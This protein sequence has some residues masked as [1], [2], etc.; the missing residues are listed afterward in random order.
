MMKKLIGTICALTLVAGM[1]LTAFAMPSAEGGQIK[2]YAA[3]GTELKIIKI[4]ESAVTGSDECNHGADCSGTI[5]II[6]PVT[7][8][9]KDEVKSLD[10]KKLIVGTKYA[11]KEWTKVFELEVIAKDCVKELLP[12]TLT[13]ATSDWVEGDP[14]VAH[15]TDGKWELVEIDEANGTFTATFDN[16]S[17]F[18]FYLEKSAAGGI[19]SPTTGDPVTLAFAAVAVGTAGLV[20]SRKR[21]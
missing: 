7:K 9:Y 1:S 14:L 17:P 18:V 21:K 13:F 8:E 10:I 6:T 2:A 11:D 16:F 5:E 19:T 4:E 3:D 20:V 12:I 15:Y